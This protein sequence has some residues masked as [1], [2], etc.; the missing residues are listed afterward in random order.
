MSVTY[1]FDQ[2]LPLYEKIV[3]SAYIDK[4][5]EYVPA[6]IKQGV[7]INS[8]IFMNYNLYKNANS[9][10]YL[11]F[12]LGPE[13]II[14][15]FKRDFFDYSR[16]KVLPFYKFKTGQSIFK[17]DQVSEKFTIDLNFDQHLIGPLL[18]ETQGILN[19]SKDSDD[20]GKFIYS[21]IGMNFK[22]R[23]YS[24]GIFYQPHDQAGGINFSLNGFK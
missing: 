7:Y 3:D 10:K 9:Q 13:I 19:L 21:R 4:S 6:P 2:K 1:H 5:F 11:G 22:K 23:S 24:L 16:L 18:I 12:G 15:N 8:K 17:F 20:Y 14:G